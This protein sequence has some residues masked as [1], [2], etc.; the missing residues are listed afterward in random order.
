M[1]KFKEKYF[2]KDKQ[3]FDESKFESLNIEINSQNLET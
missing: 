1:N 3:L 2:I